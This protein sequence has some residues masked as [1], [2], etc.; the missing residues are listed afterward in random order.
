M[1]PHEL[2]KIIFDKINPTIEVHRE[3][4]RNFFWFEGYAFVSD[5]EIE[6]FIEPTPFFDLGLKIFLC[7]K[8]Y[9]DQNARV[10]SSRKVTFIKKVYQ[11]AESFEWLYGDVKF[12][13]KPELNIEG[14]VRC[15]ED[16]LV[17]PETLEKIKI[18]KFYS[19]CEMAIEK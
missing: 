5:Q 4:K 6:D 17:L 12:I 11:W 9:Q 19:R 18:R 3:S 14:N 2:K 7:N 8:F 15:K 16:I 13:C 10:S 1:E